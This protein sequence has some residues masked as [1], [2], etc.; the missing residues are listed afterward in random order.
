M[1]VKELK[2]I[3]ETLP[4]DMEVCTTHEI[5]FD[6]H[7]FDVVVRVWSAK[8]EHHKIKHENEVKEVLLIE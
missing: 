3:L 1:L 8:L 2:K 4:P 6:D 7:T 5:G